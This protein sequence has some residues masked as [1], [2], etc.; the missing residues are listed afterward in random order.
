MHRRRR[1]EVLVRLGAVGVCH[2]DFN[3][4]DGTAETRCPA[5]LGH[6]GAGIVEAVGAGVT[7]VAVGDHVALS[8]APSCGSLRRV[9][10]GPSAAVLHRLAGDGN[11]RT[12][13]RNDAGSRATASPSITTRSSRRSRRRASSPR[14]RVCR[15][16]GTFRSTSQGS[17]AARS[18]QASARCGGR[19]GFAPAIGSRHRLWRRRTVRRDGRRRR[20]RGTGDRRRR[21]RLEARNRAIASAPRRRSLGGLGG[22]H[23]RGGSRGLG[24]R[25]RLT[26]SRRQAD[27]RRCRGVPRPRGARR[28]CA[29][30][31][32]ARGCD[33]GASCALDPAHG[34]AGSR[35]DLRVVAARA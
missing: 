26:R 3:A 30:R 25:R 21:L 6:E 9:L 15:S 7:R 17:S 2:S 27:R 19:P 14:G 33:A 24:R 16:H 23:G 18:R 1:R 22:G 8:W 4:I 32:P 34:A 11:W 28:C 13:G 20:R 31:D 35:L 12:D 10:A 5:V 29:D